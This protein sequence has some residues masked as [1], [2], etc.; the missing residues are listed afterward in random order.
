MAVGNRCLRHGLETPVGTQSRMV[1]VRG[2][3]P[4]TP[5][6]RRRCSTRLSYTPMGS[7]SC[8]PLRAALAGT[9]QSTI[10]VGA[11]NMSEASDFSK[12]LMPRVVDVNKSLT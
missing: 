10:A 2:F 6:S 12:W 3:E 5:A 8:I 9:A 4:P 7:D 1:G 11:H